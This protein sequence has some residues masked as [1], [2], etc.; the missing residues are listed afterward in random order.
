MEP[1]HDDRTLVLV[2]RLSDTIQYGMVHGSVW[3]AMYLTMQ[4][5]G[6]V[7]RGAIGAKLESLPLAML[8]SILVPMGAMVTMR[9][10]DDE[11]S[12]DGLVAT[13]AVE[14]MVE[15]DVSL[16]MSGLSIIDVVCSSK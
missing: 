12:M 13:G 7:T 6:P 9:T 4:V 8:V 1:P 10:G 14:T 3:W 2:Q 16:A 15:A 11:S 5:T